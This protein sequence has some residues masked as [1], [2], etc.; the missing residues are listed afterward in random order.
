[1]G[2]DREAAVGSQ[3]IEHLNHSTIGGSEIEE[4]LTCVLRRKMKRTGSSDV[5]VVDPHR[6]RAS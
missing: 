1:M 5:V 4:Y 6:T 2:R 3:G